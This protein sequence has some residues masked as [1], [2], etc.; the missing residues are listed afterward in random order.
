MATDPAD[1]VLDQGPVDPELEILRA[2]ERGDIDVAEATQRLAALTADPDR[3]E[4]ETDH[5]G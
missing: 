3:D 1:V 2:L 4:I 5:V